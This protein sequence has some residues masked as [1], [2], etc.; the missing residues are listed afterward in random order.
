MSMKSDYHGILMM[1]IK[2]NHRGK[3]M[4]EQEKMMEGYDRYISELFALES[5]DLSSAREAIHE[6]GLPHIYISAAEGK[7]LHLFVMMSGARRVLEIGTLGGYSAI[8]MASALPKDGMLISLEI[9]SHHADVARSSVARAGL[10]DKVDIRTGAALDSLK[11]MAAKG[12]PLFDL[13]FIDADKEG[14]ADYLKKTVPLLREGGL[15]LADNTLPDAVLDVNAVSGA[16]SYNSAVAAHPDLE[17]IIL[18]I[19]RE[20]G[21]DGLTVSIKK[22][23]K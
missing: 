8:W 9:D 2:N 23:S 19:L 10:S 11:E 5:D 16:K 18:P 20:R 14:Y 22:T 1:I 3:W 21:I 13:I 6:E 4:A 7:L 17:S 12:E 15:V